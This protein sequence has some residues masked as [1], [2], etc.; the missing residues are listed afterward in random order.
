ME[1]AARI[2][3]AGGIGGAHGG[4]GS[5]CLTVGVASVRVELCRA[6]PPMSDL[7][8][9][10][11]PGYVRVGDRHPY[12]SVDTDDK[13]WCWQQLVENDDGDQRYCFEPVDHPTHSDEGADRG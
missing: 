6:W 1:R 7:T 9:S 8:R 5:G 13:D 10:P 11:S 3:S 2:R 12:V 4:E